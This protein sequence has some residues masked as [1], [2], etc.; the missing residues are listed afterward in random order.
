MKKNHINLIL[1]ISLLSFGAF[2]QTIC[3]TVVSSAGGTLISANNQ[4]SYTIGETFTSTLNASD[5]QITQGFGQ[6]SEQIITG[7][8]STS[9][10]AGSTID[11]PFSASS[12]GS[13]NTFTAQ[14][15]DGSG[16]FALPISIGTLVGTTSGTIIATIPINTPFGTAYRIRV[17]SSV[18]LLIGSDNGSDITI[19]PNTTIQSTA[20]FYTKASGDFSNP[21]IWEYQDS[22]GNWVEAT[23]PPWIQNTCVIRSLSHSDVFIPQQIKS[24][25]IQTGGSLTIVSELTVSGGGG[26]SGGAT[27]SSIDI[28]GSLTIPVTGYLTD[29]SG[30]PVSIQSGGSIVSVGEIHLSGD[31]TIDGQFSGAIGSHGKL[32][33]FGGYTQAI[34]ANSNNNNLGDVFV[35][36][37]LLSSEVRIHNNALLTTLD[38]PLL[39]MSKG[40]VKFFNETKGFGFIKA[41]S[42]AEAKIVAGTADLFV[43]GDM[44]IHGQFDGAD[45]KLTFDGTTPQ[46]ITYDP[47]VPSPISNFGDVSFSNTSAAGLLLT[48]PPTALFFSKKGYDYYQMQSDLSCTFMESFTIGAGATM[49]VTGA[50]AMSVGG[51]WTNN[52]T[53]IPGTGTVRF[54]SSGTSKIGGSTS[55]QN[56]YNLEINKDSE[57]D[58]VDLDCDDLDVANDLTVANGS[59]KKGLNAVNVSILKRMSISPSGIFDGNLLDVSV[60][61]D[62]T[63]HGQYN[64]VDGTLTFDGSSAQA[65]DHSPDPAS[66]PSNYGELVFSNTAGGITVIG[67]T[68]PI[69]AREASAPSISEIVVTKA[70][71]ISGP[72]LINTG[73]QF[74]VTAT[75][76]L[77]IRGDMTVHGQYNGVDGKLTFDGTSAQVITYDP[78][79]PSTQSNFGDVSFSN[80]SVAGIVL[81]ST[82]SALWLSK[83]GYEYYKMQSNMAMRFQESFTIGAGATMEVTGATDITVGGDWINN[84]GTFIPAAGTVI[85][86]GSGNSIIGGTSST[87]YFNDLTIDKS[88]GS[89][90]LYECIIC[91]ARTITIQSGN[92]DAGAAT[93]IFV[94]GDWIN[95]GSFIPS[96][97]TVIFDGTGTSHIGG[98]VATETFYDL[99]TICFDLINDKTTLNVQNLKI[100]GGKFTGGPGTITLQRNMTIDEGG[101]FEPNLGTVVFNGT[102]EQ[103]LTGLTSTGPRN[104][105]FH[106]LTVNNGSDYRIDTFTCCG[107]GSGRITV[108]GDLELIAGKIKL[109]CDL[110]IDTNATITGASPTRYIKTEGKGTLLQLNSL[111]SS[112]VV[113]PIGTETGYSPVT[114]QLFSST[115]Q[116]I[117]LGARVADGVSTAYDADENPIGNAI[118]PRSVLKTFFATG[119][120]PPGDHI[121]IHPQWNV[122]DE[123]ID[124]DRTVC[125]LAHYTGGQWVRSTPT[126]AVPGDS[127]GS[128]SGSFNVAVTSLSPFAVFSQNSSSCSTLGEWTGVVSSDWSNPNNWC[129]GT[130]PTATTNVV[131]PSGTP[132]QPAITTGA[133]VGIAVGAVIA[134]L[135]IENGATLTLS[136][137]LELHVSGDMTVHGQYNGFDGKLVFDGTSAQVFD[138]SPDATSPPSNFGELEF[139]NT[140]GGITV[141]GNAIPIVAREAS[142]PS[143]SEVVITKQMDVASTVLFSSGAK[144]TVTATGELFVGGDMTVHGQY[145]GVD[146]KLTF[147]GTSAQVFDFS[148]D[149]ASPPSNFGELVFN[150]TAGGI[151]VIGNTIPILAREASAPSISEIVIT[152]QMDIASTVLFSSSSKFTVTATGELSVGGDLT[153]HGQY[154]GVDG[155][156]TFDGVSAQVFDFS[157]DPASPPSNFG[158]LVFNNTAGGITV[159]GNTIPILAR[160]ASAPSISEI[161]VSK[162]MDMSSTVLFSSSSKFTVTATGELSVGGDLT[163]HG[164]YNGVDGKLTFDGSSAQVFDFSPDPASPPSNFGELVFSNTAGGVT[165]IGNAIPIVAREASA[166]SISE[167]VVTKS[168]DISGPVLINPGATFTVTTTGELTVGGAMTVH[169]QYNGVDGKL[170]LNGTTAQVMTYDPPAASPQSNFGDVS[171]SNTSASGIQITGS[172]LAI[173]AGRKGYQY[174]KAQSDMR[175]AFQE[176]FTIGTGATMEVI[177]ATDITV[178]GDWINNGGT[179][180]PGAGTVIFN[181]SGNS[182]IGG[183]SSTQ[184]FNDITIDKSVGTSITSWSFPVCHARTITIQSGNLDA[185]TATELFVSGDWIN[186]GGTFTPGSSTVTFNGSE[187]SII[188]GTSLNQRLG[189]VKVVKDLTGLGLEPLIGVGLNLDLLDVENIRLQSGELRAGTADISISGDWIN[190]GGTFIPGA[191]TVIFNGSGNSIIGGTSS[192]QYFNDLTV[193]KSNVTSH[194]VWQFPVCHARTITI[195]SGN[196]DAGTATDIFVSGNWINNGGTFDP[197]TST[198][199]FDGTAVQ[200]I[201][202]VLS[203]FHKL[204][205]DNATGLEIRESPSFPKLT[206]VSGD[207]KLTNGKIYLFG[208]QDLQLVSDAT[209]T[210]ASPTKYIV[211]NGKGSLKRQLITFVGGPNTQIVYP[212]GTQTGYKPVTYQLFSVTGQPLVLGARVADGVSTA[213]D[214]DENPIG[215]AISPRSILITF[216]A[217]GSIP[218]GD[219]IKMKLQWNG[220]D[221]GVG[222]DRSSCNLGHYTGGQWVYSD[223][224]A[225]VSG[226]DPGAYTG[227]FN[228][229]LTSLSP[230][231]VFSQSIT[232]SFAGTAF[233]AG[234]TLPITY[235]ASSGVWNAGNIFKA[236]LSDVAGNFPGTIIGSLTSTALTGTINAIIPITTTGGSSYRIRVNSTDTANLGIDNGTNVT[237][238]SAAASAGSNGTLT[239]CAGTNPTPAQLFAAL[240]GSP[241]SGGVWSGPVLGVY[242]YTQSG[243][244]SCPSNSATVTV[245]YTPNTTLGSANVTSNAPYTWPLPYGTGLTYTTSGVFT[246]TIGCNVATLNLIITVNTFTIGTNCGATISGLNVTINTPLVSA[247]VSY[248]FRVKNLAT[249]TVQI[250]TRPVN[251]VA[252]SN[253][254]GITFGTPYQID[255]STNGGVSYGPTCV[256]N[257]PSPTSTLDAQCGTILTS[258][259]QYVNC[260]YYANISG[261]RFRITN[262]TTNA[263]QIIDSGLNRFSFSQVG[264]PMRTF[265]TTY[266]VEVALKN[267]DGSYLPYSAGC[268]VTTAPF[269]TTRIRPIQ[270][271]EVGYQASS[272]TENFQAIIVA[273]A[274]EYRFNLF[275]TGIG[276][277][278][279][280]D[281]NLNTF[282]L[283]LFSGLLPG[284]TYSVRVALKIDGN[285]GPFGVACKIITPGLSKTV[286]AISNEFIAVAYPNPFANDFMIN[287][288]TASESSLQ[289][290]VYDMLGKQIDNQNVEVSDIENLQLGA[291]YPSGIYNIIVSQSENSQT[292][293]VIKR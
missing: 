140:A 145:N 35:D 27:G 167:I 192:T 55:P 178:G 249:N 50:T 268:R 142:A 246:N 93:D 39:S 109:N 52:G 86:N 248:M 61:G 63:V 161:S 51:D 72:V 144:L 136:N 90:C 280:L 214:S 80:T 292:L 160:E 100:V 230:F 8:V 37:T 120:I 5:K 68:I 277:S 266:F 225:A 16:S 153:V 275:N 213:Y 114:Y 118:L 116:P 92:L 233:C 262:T 218:N 229:V 216:F 221:E 21:S 45:C 69:V 126:A 267:T 198:V 117:V 141:I 22:C 263:V 20:V 273:G 243:S 282:N 18:P 240:T 134:A 222:F 270:C 279:T 208:G 254:A 104:I 77:S 261:Y 226:D 288:K 152:K 115:G 67:N 235:T 291:N 150:N 10:C 177:G 188:G 112:F 215:N 187:N 3:R 110:V 46:V 210:G 247:V 173:W 2:T 62:M 162:K 201:E 88:V 98:T 157:P 185:G 184:Y 95:N 274:S 89:S 234:Q 154:N 78:P 237:I 48:G 60:G 28:S 84:G 91:H 138:H 251:S 75:G 143:I 111:S 148:P 183:T 211:T 290:K 57:L 79:V 147:D 119:T 174:Y 64:G 196:L 43:R 242:T 103:Q 137:N 159:I 207:L 223:A 38:F 97:S 197:R 163:V 259:T 176:S 278:S 257:T 124:F 253:Y 202:G 17:V 269:P 212:I 193:N 204:T 135:R 258:M 190:N 228:V 26:G 286:Q 108:T 255:V 276:Y 127:P 76:E 24:L 217:T 244:S 158:E 139:S 200:K 34:T 164:Q 191:G 125:D 203:S 59:V 23:L 285:W 232:N 70:M 56:F 83:K 128:Y 151:T 293:R 172:L 19:T 58:R 195:Q 4:I 256:V 287:V 206:T 133:V 36:K 107:V 40:T 31:M 289:I 6:P 271:N 239:V 87:Q 33:L 220:A 29:S 132:N 96:N 165:V 227:S 194:T 284:T 180:I 25:V 12:I 283:N 99:K 13:G 241:A 219:Y 30:E 205:V 186:N 54:N 265:A 44:T 11:V 264:L 272:T 236:E 81:T 9:I 85:F 82:T 130:L 189:V 146:G 74:T 179:F 105:L 7:A 101:L 129:S 123:G 15:S 245:S 94:S 47:P 53:F 106:N 73:A 168:I 175:M 250:I 252:L 131:I 182:I 171:F 169:G 149:P 260:T 122:A 209:I 170:T 102:V 121:T 14:L 238:S 166:P 281:R 41:E 65:F 231:A 32:Y 71:D 224:T 66:P 42:S 155:K 113:Y 1:S 199:I 181:G 156:L 49:E